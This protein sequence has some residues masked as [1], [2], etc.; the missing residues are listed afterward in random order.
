MS[1]FGEHF[2]NSLN[3]L[4]REHVT[5]RDANMKDLLEKKTGAKLKV[6]RKEIEETRRESLDDSSLTQ[7]SLSSQ[8]QSYLEQIYSGEHHE[9][10][11]CD[12][13]VE[14]V[15]SNCLK[16]SLWSNPDKKENREAVRREASPKNSR[17]TFTETRNE[18][19]TFLSEQIQQNQLL[20][21]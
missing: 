2:F 20:R 9:S 4:L 7:F 12:E 10:M 8:E 11:D 15:R 3:T 5:K 19:K 17:V 6:S 21:E 1:E 16:N 14:S 13:T 18:N